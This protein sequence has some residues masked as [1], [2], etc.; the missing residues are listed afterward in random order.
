MSK[1]P[2]TYLPLL[3][4]A[5]LCALPHALASGQT[6]S[7]KGRVTSKT[8]QERL[9]GVNVILQGSMRGTSTNSEGEFI[10]SDIP[11]GEYG[12][13]FSLLGYQRQS[14]TRVKI[15]AGRTLEIAV[16]LLPVPIQSEAV[17]VTASKR[18][19]SLLEVPVSVSVLDAASIQNRNL[20]TIDE[21]LRYVP[22]VNMT[23]FQVNIRG[24]S[25]YSRG[26]GGRVLLLI[27]GIPLL[28]ADTGELNFETMPVLQVDRI[29]VVKGA[30]SA[31]YGSSALGGVINVIT[32]PIPEDPETRVR[33]YSGFYSD[34]SYRQWEWGGGTR[35][36]DGQSVSSSRRFNDLGIML[37]ASRMADD[38]YRQNDYRRRYNAY[39]RGT[40]AFSPFDA[41]ALTFSLMDQKRGDF[42]HWKDLTHA[43]VPSDDQQGHFVR[44]TRF[45]VDGIYN[46]VASTNFYYSVKGLWFWNKFWDNI[47]SGGDMS[48]SDVWR[49]EVQASWIPG[50][51]QTLTFGAEGHLERVDASLFGIHSGRGAAIYAQ[52]ELQIMDGVKATVGARLDFQDTDSLE[53]ASQLN[54]KA[55]LVYT[56]AP[57]TFVRASYGRGFRSPAVAEAFVRTQVSGLEVEPNPSLKPERSSSYEIG[58]T[59]LL[60]EAALVDAALFQSDLENLIESG[61][62]PAGRVQFRNVTKARIQGAE[63]SAKLG[64]LHKA[65]FLEVSYTYLDPKDR[66][67][68]DILKYRPRDLLYT[69]ALA[70]IGALSLGVDFRYISRVE[71]I[72]EELVNL[73]VIK[74]GDQRVAI[75]VTDLRCGFDFAAMNVP[76]VATLNVKNLFQYNYVELIGN[77]APPR[78]MALTLEARL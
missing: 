71:R 20:V 69:S 75:Y 63:L 37:F 64:L 51:G 5:V 54:P 78:S 3:L 45:F 25:G 70:H 8:D 18:E 52:D 77:M 50:A 58:V 66:T 2:V 29:E 35:F 36:F 10:F 57:G 26:V 15:A 19:E 59:Q 43:L 49:S 61:I 39:V 27:D 38:G 12:L 74:D 30:S 7:L 41:L 4:L 6:G 9:A 16:E 24:S 42:L 40:Y 11:P 47:S 31:L 23:E 62:N 53:S 34:P 55:G 65:L 14:V 28:T 73:G 1:V 46:H 76:L 21:A 17:V 44:S 48:R 60:G 56:P 22:G 68:N 67:E 33:T 13:T 72:D 32:R